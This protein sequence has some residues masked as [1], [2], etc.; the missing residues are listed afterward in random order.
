[1]GRQ[2]VHEE[3][4]NTSHIPEIQVGPGLKLCLAMNMAKEMMGE[5]APLTDNI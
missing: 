2:L 4:E 1:M 5:A 3:V